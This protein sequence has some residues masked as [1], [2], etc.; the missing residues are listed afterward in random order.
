MKRIL[1]VVFLLLVSCAANDKKQE[2]N[3]QWALPVEA[4]GVQNLFQIN[5]TLYR[6]AQPTKEGMRSLKAMGIKT[7]INLRPIHSDKSEIVSTG[8]RLERVM[9]SP[10]HIEDKDVVTV[11]KIVSNKEN[12]PFLIHCQKGSDRT[13]LMCAMYRIVFQAW[14]KKDALDE[15]VNGGYGFSPIW[16]NIKEYIEKADI[17]KIRKEIN[18]SGVK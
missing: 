16:K 15:M 4:K 18:K 8:L 7:I 6:S 10:W 12:K 17:D 14:T 3:P 1:P 9:V 11:M 5:D 2:R 13:G